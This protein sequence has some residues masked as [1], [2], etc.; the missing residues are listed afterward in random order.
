MEQFL[1]MKLAAVN[2][3]LDFSIEDFIAKQVKISKLSRK[4][5]HKRNKKKKKKDLLVVTNSYP[6]QA[7]AMCSTS[8]P[9]MEISPDCLQYNPIK[10]DLVYASELAVN[11]LDMGLR[12][13]L[14]APIS[15]PGN[16]F[17]PASFN[18]IFPLL[19]QEIQ[20]YIS[21]CSYFSL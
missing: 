10:Q 11:Q 8:M 3:K 20:I 16:S 19:V 1:S 9:T 7:F 12:R 21:F 13:A 2:P 15:M 17:D 18:V 4:G 14:S 5:K 6:Q